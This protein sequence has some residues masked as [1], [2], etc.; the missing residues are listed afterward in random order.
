MSF[1][2]DFAGYYEAVFPLEED[3]H[4]FLAARA[5]AGSRVLDIGCGT[6]DHCGRFAAL[7]HEAVGVDLDPAM[8]A[9]AGERFPAARFHVMNMSDVSTLEGQFGCVFCIGNVLSHL[10]AEELPA[11]LESVAGLLVPEGAWIFQTV[12]WDHLLELYAFRF[13]DIVIPGTDVVFEREYPAVRPDSTSFVTR[14]RRGAELVFEG[15]VELF[16]LRA[17]EYRTTHE[18]LFEF[19]GHFASYAESPFD[20]RSMSSS[21]FHFAKR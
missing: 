5:P 6:G 15:S 8:V 7:G 16:P 3:T 20:A 18:D 1:Y 12:N 4:R 21:V 17:S 13:P 19:R 11:F 9:V 2:S 10:K 14:L